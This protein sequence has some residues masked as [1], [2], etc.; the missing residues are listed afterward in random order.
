[1]SIDNES[2]VPI[3]IQEELVKAGWTLARST[4]IA[5]ETNTNLF[6][7]GKKGLQVWKLNNIYEESY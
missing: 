6:T 3:S 4:F 1:M 2:F 7:N 5:N